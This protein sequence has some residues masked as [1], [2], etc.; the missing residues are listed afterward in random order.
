MD[1][2]ELLNLNCTCV[3]DIHKMFDCLCVCTCCASFGDQTSDISQ[4]NTGWLRW[5][6]WDA[7]T[8]R[9]NREQET[10]TTHIHRQQRVSASHSN[11]CSYVSAL[12]HIKQT[13]GEK[14][15]W[16]LN[17]M[18]E[19]THAP[20]HTHTRHTTSI[21]CDRRDLAIIR[22]IIIIILV[23]VM[24]T[25]WIALLLIIGERTRVC[26][27]NSTETHIRLTQTQAYIYILARSAK[28]MAIT[29]DHRHC[30]RVKSINK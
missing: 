10:H 17:T 27:R 25:S 9:K 7:Q 6:R 24:E 14:K 22:T 26:T 23:D 28:A 1:V 8:Q 4:N 20:V 5:R 19:P 12:Q 3:C 11:S 13:N 15:I 21:V 29:D 16:P 2:R 18:Y 30:C